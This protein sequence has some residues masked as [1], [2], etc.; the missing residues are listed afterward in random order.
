VIL[1]TG[2]TGV[3]G[4]ALLR[5]IVAE[6][7]PVRCLV[8][9]PRRLG[10][11]RV[12]VQIALGDLADPA[13][14]RNALRGV[15]TVIHLGASIRD[16]PRG[17]IEEL[18]AVATMRL[19]R[20]AERAGVERFVLFSALGAELHSRTRFFRAKALACR[21]VEESSLATTVFA[22]SIVYTP[23]DPWLTLLE[24]LSLLPAVPV[25]GSGR[26][27]YQPIWAEDVADCVMA[28]LAD[29]GA[30]GRSFELAGPDTLSYASIVRTVMRPLGRRRPLLPVPLPIVRLS[31]EALERVVGPAAFA[32]WEE[33][34]LMEEP[35]TTGRGTADAESLGVSPLPMSAVLGAS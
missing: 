14:F 21:A 13:S 25:S 20:A 16:Q 7:E 18:N 30:G 17:S 3:I 22:P 24:R 5:R 9:D 11:Q 4:S 19:V 34:E 33:A 27:Q 15:H 2:G 8:R 26:S 10:E 6:R 28:A 35:M 1:L 23:G 32:T 29:G 12:R 31:L